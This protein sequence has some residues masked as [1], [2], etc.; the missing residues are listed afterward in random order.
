ML[1]E[2]RGRR[3]NDLVWYDGA[4]NVCDNGHGVI[5][6]IEDNGHYAQV[7]WSCP[8]GPVQRREW[9]GDLT[10]FVCAG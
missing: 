5:V 4:L 3:V 9:L 8:N 10:R 1:T 6:S 2:S 7:E